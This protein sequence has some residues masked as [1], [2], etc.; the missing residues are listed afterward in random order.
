[1]TSKDKTGDQLVASIRKSKSAASAPKVRAGSPR[2][3]RPAA[4]P[5]AKPV[6]KADKQN[7]TSTYQ[8]GRRVWP[9]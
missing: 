6:A 5:R 9:D 2:T 8:V 7:A 4:K 1:M 3:A